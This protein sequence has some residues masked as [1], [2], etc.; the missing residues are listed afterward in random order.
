MEALLKIRKFLSDQAYDG[1][2]LTRRDNYFWLTGGHINHVMQNTEIGVASLLITTDQVSI[3]AD[4]SDAERICTEQNPLDATCI[5][6][7]WYGSVEDE[8]RKQIEGKKVVSDSGIAGTANVNHLLVP[9]RMQ[10]SPAEISAYRELGRES[11]EILENIVLSAKPGQTE[12]ELSASLHYNMLQQGIHADCI[13]IGSDERILRYRH[14]MP[15]EKKIERSLMVVAGAER[16]GL[17]VSLTRIAYFSSIPDDIKQ[18]YNAVQ[19]IFAAMQ[20]QMKDGLP[21][22][23]YFASVQNMYAEYCYSDE[24]K[25]HHQGGPTGYGCREMVI[26]PNSKGT[27][28]NNQAYAWNPTI[29]GTKCEETTLLTESSLET[30]TM[31]AQWPRKKVESSF[32]VYD[33]ADIIQL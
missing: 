21:Y 1:I 32:G 18:K 7:P 10:L 20:C 12:N 27:I 14:P 15:S 9:L 11:A 33:V 4:C 13:L 17:W 29:T 3:I 26:N 22:K 24:W 31:T 28:K 19:Q 5:T 2:I 23:D 30:L 25:L 6:V 16:N 8:I